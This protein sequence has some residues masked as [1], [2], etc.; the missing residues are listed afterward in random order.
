MKGTY[1][2]ACVSTCLR[3][4]LCWLHKA[5][6]RP[7]IDLWMLILKQPSLLCRRAH[8]GDRGIVEQSSGLDCQPVSG[9]LPRSSTLQGALGV[10][11]GGTSKSLPLLAVGP[12]DEET[13]PQSFRILTGR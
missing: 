2:L 8:D 4:E 3:N 6:N 10:H 9:K 1:V 5:S 13:G 11:G 7:E 12:E